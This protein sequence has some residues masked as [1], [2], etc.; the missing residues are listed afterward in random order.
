MKMDNIKAMMARKQNNQRQKR[1]K[2]AKEKRIEPIGP[3]PE[4]KAHG[5]Y[6]DEFVHHH[7]TGTKTKATRNRRSHIIDKWIEDGGLGFEGGAVTAIKICEFLWERSM[8]QKLTASYGERIHGS[9]E[10][11]DMLEAISKISDL[12]RGIPA[13]YWSIFENIVRFRQ[14]AGVAGSDLATNTS[15]SIASAKAVVGFVACKIAE[16]ERY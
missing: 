11:M 10:G 4:A 3:T 13:P 14:P 16:K 8:S 2:P 15:Q 9:V 12:K 5:D 6:D 7:E 1:A